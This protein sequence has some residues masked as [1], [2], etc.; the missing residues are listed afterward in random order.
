[1]GLCVST[2]AAVHVVRGP[3]GS[4]IGGS[5]SRT[6]Q[7]SLRGGDQLEEHPPNNVGFRRGGAR[8][9]IGGVVVGRLR[10]DMRQGGHYT[11]IGLIEIK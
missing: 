9:T 6:R 2:F 7:E 10:N 11:L 3:T 5:A 4:S 1:M 8:T